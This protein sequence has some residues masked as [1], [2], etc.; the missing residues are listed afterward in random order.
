[1]FRGHVDVLV[2]R[3]VQ[4]GETLSDDSSLLIY[5]PLLIKSASAGSGR[6]GIFSNTLHMIQSPT[7]NM[8]LNVLSWPYQ[9][10]GI[11]VTLWLHIFW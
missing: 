8:C 2:L 1:M 6:I 3:V 9:L 10:L 7:T 5:N 11:L 4:T